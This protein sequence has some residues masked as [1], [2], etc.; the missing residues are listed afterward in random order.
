MYSQLW[1]GF[2]WPRPWDIC[3]S[4]A[5]ELSQYGFYGEHICEEFPDLT[6]VEFEF[7]MEQVLAV[8][9]RWAEKPKKR[10]KRTTVVVEIK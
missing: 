9:F 4:W 8:G 10:F 3:Y 1:V 6:N 5:W 7:A 2:E